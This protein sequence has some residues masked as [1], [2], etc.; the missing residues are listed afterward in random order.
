M[1]IRLTLSTALFVCLISTH[2]TA[3]AVYTIRDLGSFSPTAINT[4]AQVV[5]A[6]NNHAYI[7]DNLR[8]LR[9]LGTLPG[10]TFS[11]A[12]DINDLG[13]V[14]GSADAPTTVINWYPPPATLQ[15]TELTQPFIWKHRNGMS[16]LA[17]PTSY[18]HTPPIFPCQV[19]LTATSLSLTGQ[20]VGWTHFYQATYQWGFVW[21]KSGGMSAFGGS[22]TPTFI[23]QISNIGEIVGQNSQDSDSGGLRTMYL[24]HA[25]TWKNGVATDL[26]TLG[27]AADMG[28]PYGYSSSADG[29][30][31][32]GQVVGWSTTVPLNALDYGTGYPVHAVL[33]NSTGGMTDLGTLP[34][35]LVAVA[36]KINLFGIAIGTSGNTFFF[37]G[38]SQ[39][40]YV[41]GHPFVWTASSGMLDLNTLINASSGWTLNSVTDINVWGQI[42]GQGTLN[43]QPHGFLLT[44]Q[45]PFQLF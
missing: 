39:P 16:G 7:W 21:T 40:A 33:W 29:V 2:A 45:N 26:G 42:V 8:G 6:A 37:D 32:L 35:D 41:T 11:A 14:T 44:P 36:S 3:Q 25:T 1:W 23:N 20:V 18:P 4:W 13:R 17:D 31:D 10:G 24:G 34:G 9:D 27:G 28:Y 43:G 30:N 5:G 15:C 22:W 38:W 19:P 12:T